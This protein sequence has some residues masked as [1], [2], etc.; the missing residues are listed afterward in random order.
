MD[1][2][3]FIARIDIL[4]AIFEGVNLKFATR[5]EAM[6]AEMLHLIDETVHDL[7]WEPNAP[8]AIS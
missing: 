8:P 4:G 7:R 6:S 1:K 3:E 2:A 5:T